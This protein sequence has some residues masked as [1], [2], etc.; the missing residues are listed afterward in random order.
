M[1]AFVSHHHS[2]V[3]CCEAFRDKAHVILDAS[4]SAMKGEKTHL[5]RA[6]VPKDNAA[7]ITPTLWI[8]SRARDRAL[9][10]ADSFGIVNSL[11][12]AGG[13]L[14]GLRSESVSARGC[15]DGDDDM[16]QY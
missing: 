8:V 2:A 4:Q 1:T 5:H 13:A 6:N 16:I 15:G 14:G 10:S 3:N 9:S 11:S 7:E 12:R